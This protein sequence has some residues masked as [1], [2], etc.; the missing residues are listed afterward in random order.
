LSRLHDTQ[1]VYGVSEI[2]SNA[3]SEIFEDAR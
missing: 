3:L 2:S 1:M